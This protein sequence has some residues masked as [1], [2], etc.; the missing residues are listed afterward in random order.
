MWQKEFS[1][2]KKLWVKKN[3]VSFLGQN[4]YLGTKSV[5]YKKSWL[6]EKNFRSENILLK[7]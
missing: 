4:K 7:F 2:E 3:V 1:L 5:G 6:E